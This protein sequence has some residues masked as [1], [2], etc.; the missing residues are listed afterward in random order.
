MAD[1]ALASSEYCAAHDC[2]TER[3]SETR[4]SRSRSRAIWL[5]KSACAGDSDGRPAA[6]DS[7][8]EA[9]LGFSAFGEGDPVEPVGDW[10][11]S[12][13]SSHSRRLDSGD[14]ARWPEGG[15]ARR[16]APWQ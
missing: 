2:E 7:R 8:L 14:M 12:V 4:L 16:T 10:F 11:M 3:C 13:P 6:N 1:R 5:L 9:R 15:A